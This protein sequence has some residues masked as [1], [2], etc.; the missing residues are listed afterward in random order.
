[1]NYNPNWLDKEKIIDDKLS[2]IEKQKIIE[3]ETL[4]GIN[5]KDVIII[6]NWL[7]YA[8]KIGDDTYKIICDD[9]KYSNY[10]DSKLSEDIIN[11][12]SLN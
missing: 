7:Y 12:L 1:M 6:Y 4:R 5:I 8:K 2:K 11:N 3:D 10:I 9:P